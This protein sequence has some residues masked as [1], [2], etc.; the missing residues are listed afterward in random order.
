MP[1]SSRANRTFVVGFVAL[2]LGL[3]ALAAVLIL[4]G[5]ADPEMRARVEQMEDAR[6]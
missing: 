6:R 4:R 1:L 2:M 5:W 3:A